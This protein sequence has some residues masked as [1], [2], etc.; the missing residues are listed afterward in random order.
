MSRV[1]DLLLSKALRLR[2]EPLLLR[3]RSGF[4][5]ALAAP[6]ERFEEVR[7]YGNVV[8]GSRDASHSE[9]VLTK[10]VRELFT[11]NQV[12]RRRSISCRFCASIRRKR[13]RRN[14]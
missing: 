14:Q 5:L 11:I 2:A 10:Q 13:S 3:W 4:F 9:T 7:M 8:D 6:L 12:D 1:R